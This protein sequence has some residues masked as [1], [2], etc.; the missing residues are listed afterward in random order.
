MPHL[1]DREIQRRLN[2][3]RQVRTL[4]N[5]VPNDIIDV[6]ATKVVVR[7]QR[8]RRDREILHRWIRNPHHSGPHGC[9]IRALAQIV[10][11]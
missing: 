8:T 11:L 5:D 4:V 3:I 1:T 7:S 10:G 6:G 9:I 2:P